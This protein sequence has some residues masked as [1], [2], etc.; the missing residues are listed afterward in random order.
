MHV[1]TE[2]TRSQLHHVYL[3]KARGLRDDLPA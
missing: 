3:E 2:R 1:T